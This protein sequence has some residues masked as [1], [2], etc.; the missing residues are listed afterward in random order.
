[1]FFMY[2]WLYI[3]L[4]ITGCLL[5][6]S[7]YLRVLFILVM[8]IIFQM[9]LV[10]NNKW[11]SRDSL[12][13]IETKDLYDMLQDGDVIMSNVYPYE[14]Q[15]N[16]YISSLFNCG[17]IHNMYVMEEN[18]K[19]YMMGGHMDPEAAQSKRLIRQVKTIAGKDF[20]VYMEPL[21]EY[22]LENRN[23]YIYQIL[24]HPTSPIRLTSQDMKWS[25]KE[26]IYYCTHTLAHIFVRQGKM[27]KQKN[28]FSYRP[29]RLVST[30]MN[31]GYQMTTVRQI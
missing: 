30:L 29:K 27:E 21:M 17:L 14:K 20:Y 9:T 16:R 28:A 24:R 25:E 4:V 15:P 10:Y 18:G 31:H 22:L 13:K 7:W 1:M 12:P 19:K 3:L 6:I 8:F 11:N 26:P 5:P 2:T 23:N